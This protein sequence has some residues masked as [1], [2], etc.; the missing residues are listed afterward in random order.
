MVDNSNA[1]RRLEVARGIKN[2]R[3]SIDRAFEDAKYHGVIRGVAVMTKGFVKDSR[4]WEIDDMT[5]SQIVDAGNKHA[6]LGVKARFGHPNMSSSALGTFLGRVKNFSV[7][8]DIARGDL[9]LSK[10]AYATPEGDLAGYVLNLAEEDPAAFGTSAVMG[11]FELEKRTEKDAQ[12]NPL[13][14]LLRIQSLSAVDAV[15]DPATNNGMFGKFFNSSVELSA[16]ASEYLDKLLNDQQSL[17]YVFAFLERYR[18]N[19]GR[20]EINNNDQRKDK[21]MEFKDITQE[22][23]QKERPE[24][25]VALQ[26][27]AIEGERSRCSKIVKSAHSEFTG[28]GMEGIVEE[29]VDNG[30]TVDATLASMRGKRL[31]DL[32]KEANKAPGADGDEPPVKPTHLDRAKKYKDEHKCSMV[33]ALKATAEARK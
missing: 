10:S 7:D 22:Q 20:D 29:A 15:D 28:M 3:A 17:D 11:G 30:K 8:G 27:E 16:K 25:V 12:G 6:G 24:L 1:I 32:K 13:P 23:L 2:G 19:S 26:R 21:V 18:V 14:P 31:E 4:G 5:L 9:F 33:D